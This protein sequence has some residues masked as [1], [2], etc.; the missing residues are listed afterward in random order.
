MKSLQ[1]VLALCTFF[2]LAQAQITGRVLDG[3]GNPLS[4][5]NVRAIVSNVQTETN[6]DGNFSLNIPNHTTG[7]APSHWANQPA[8]IPNS[9]VQFQTTNQSFII[10]TAHSNAMYTVDGKQYG[11]TPRQATT[12][13]A[14][15]KPFLAK[16]LAQPDTLVFTQIGFATQRAAI[17]DDEA[18]I[19]DIIMDAVT[20]YNITVQA[21]SGGS[22]EPWEGYGF[23]TQLPVNEGEALT[24]TAQPNG[25]F[26]VDSIVGCG[27]TLDSLTFITAPVTK[28]C[29]ILVAFKHMPGPPIINNGLS[30][31]IHPANGAT[32]VARTP[33][34]EWDPNY[35]VST[36]GAALAY[37][38]YLC[39]DTNG[40][41]IAAAQDQFVRVAEDLT[42]N[43]YTHTTNLKP[44]THY[45]WDIV[46]KDSNGSVSAFF[47]NNRRWEFTTTAPGDLLW[48]FSSIRSYGLGEGLALAMDSLGTSYVGTSRG[49]IIALDKFGSEKWVN[50]DHSGPENDPANKVVQIAVSEQGQIVVFQGNGI[51]YDRISVLDS[52]AG[53]LVWT[54]D[55]YTT[56]RA[57]SAQNFAI[58]ASNTIRL[59]GGVVIHEDDALL[60]RTEIGLRE[61]SMNDGSEL[62]LYAPVYE[63]ERHY[64]WEYNIKFAQPCVS[65]DA[66]ERAYLYTEEYASDS[67]Y[68]SGYISYERDIKQTGFRSVGSDSTTNWIHQHTENDDADHLQSFYTGN[69]E[70]GHLIAI[71]ADN[72]ILAR[73]NYGLHKFDPATGD[74]AWR[75]NEQTIQSQIVVDASDVI[76]VIGYKNST[77]PILYAI[78]GTTGLT[79]WSLEL[80]SHILGGAKGNEQVILM[81]EDNLLVRTGNDALVVNRDAKEVI[82]N[83]REAIQESDLLVSLSSMIN[84]T[85][86]GIL[87]M[88]GSKNGLPRLDALDFTAWGGL[89]QGAPWPIAGQNAGRTFRKGN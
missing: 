57:G 88:G 44:N 36:T 8:F 3:Q 76:Y 66:L 21:G 10:H 68:T 59:V 71:G 70:K 40:G 74:I 11:Q 47:D 19:E 60:R 2:T 16:P 63:S 23:K 54:V 22:V 55:R 42:D 25:G 69:F 15:A 38:V 46:A 17:D 83:Y 52:A 72:G 65:I 29:T 64:V 24:L 20:I 79:T 50:T 13:A 53:S 51:E 75:W 28:L 30:Q 9:W 48:S 7:L 87:V 41:C 49:S 39:D 4:G 80:A 84:L 6:Y 58:T 67:R 35:F 37:D 43:N 73:S 45:Y 27:G 34:F 31:S 12:K 32:K 61:L 82:W 77:S 62:S 86:D 26:L 85:P 78:D 81:N 18:A 89:E 33:T 5:V 14:L 1:Y 56:S